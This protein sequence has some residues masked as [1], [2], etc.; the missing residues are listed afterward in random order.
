MKLRKL[1]RRAI[2]EA[3]EE[4]I[5]SYAKARERGDLK[6]AWA[7]LERAHILS[8]RYLIRHWRTHWLM[9]RMARNARDRRE[10]RGQIRRLG[11]V[12]FGWIGGWVPKGNTGG[13]NVHPLRP[14][15]LD[16]DLEKILEGYS[17]WKDVAV[18]LVIVAAI[19]GFLFLAYNAWSSILER[20]GETLQITESASDY[21]ELVPELEG[22]EDIVIDSVSG[23]GFAVGGDRRSFRT[24]GEGRSRIFAFPLN[25]PMAAIVITPDLPRELKGF[26][27]D[28]FIDKRGRLWLGVANRS[29]IGHSVEVYE[30]G[31]RESLRHHATLSAPGFRNPNDLVLLSPN[32]ALVTLDKRSRAGSVAE[33]FEGARRAETGRVVQVETGK[34][35]VVADGL[36]SSNGIVQ[37]EDG[38]IVVGEL[39]GR[40]IS[41]FNQTRANALSLERRITLPFAV[42]NLST[43]DGRSLW[44]AGHPK[45]FTLARGYQVDEEKK[46]PS[47]AVSVDPVT[48][49][50]KKLFE[51][52]G[53]FLSASSIAV[54]LPNG[55]FLVGTAFGPAAAWCDKAR[56]F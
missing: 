11:A 18:R 40:R 4:A 9:L 3:Y 22:A 47:I 43:P 29:S 8:Q 42:D 54:A 30:V 14:M 16:S 27:A 15:P 28:L 44:A 20:N 36:L 19:L 49:R 35:A 48:G 41:I 5:K 7:Q 51:D 38:K 33:I 56:S 39:V 50:V 26:G 37:L 6:D 52:D 13:V 10:V 21:C 23:R 12:P 2:R 32:K 55:T 45:L 46:A 34:M 1:N 24:G 17:P 31:A 25:D 53:Q